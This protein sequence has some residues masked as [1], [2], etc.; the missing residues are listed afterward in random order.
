[1]ENVL[2]RYRFLTLWHLAFLAI[3][4]LASYASVPFTISFTW[5]LVVLMG[6]LYTSWVYPKKYV[7]CWRGECYEETTIHWRAIIDLFMHI[8]PFLFVC[9]VYFWRPPYLN[10]YIPRDGHASWIVTLATILC[11]ALVF[12]DIQA[13]Y[14]TTKGVLFVIMLTMGIG[15]A[16]ETR[17]WL[18]HLK[19][20][21]ILKN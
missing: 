14:M 13:I 4:I 1:M 21:S 12:D 17:L 19:E 20:I 7:F 15:L 18:P 2:G 5:V 11:Y 16:V 6:G 9:Y 10:L 8:A 3:A